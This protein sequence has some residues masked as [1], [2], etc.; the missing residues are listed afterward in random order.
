VN[1]E[2]HGNVEKAEENPP[3]R[4]KVQDAK[5]GDTLVAEDTVAQLEDSATVANNK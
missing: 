2:Q 3:K 5:D 1:D 4:I